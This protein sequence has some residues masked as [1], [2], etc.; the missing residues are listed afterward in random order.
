MFSIDTQSHR[1]FCPKFLS[2]CLNHV[3]ANKG[4]S[5]LYFGSQSG[6]TALIKKCTTNNIAP[7]EPSGVSKETEKIVQVISFQG[8]G[9]PF[10]SQNYIKY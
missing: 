10:F 2:N 3:E 7:R 1:E 8:F 9:A 4:A 6:T 5:A